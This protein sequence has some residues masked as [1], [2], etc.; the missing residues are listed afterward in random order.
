MTDSPKSQN[1][2]RGTGHDAVLPFATAISW[3]WCCR[4][5]PRPL[6]CGRKPPAAG[7]RLAATGC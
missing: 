4:C 5:C 2:Q 1:K 3:Y 7:E 6:P